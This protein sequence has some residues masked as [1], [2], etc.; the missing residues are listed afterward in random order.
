MQKGT[1][2]RL[3][4]KGYGFIKTEDSDKDLFFHANEFQGE[5]ETLAEGDSVE[6]E[7]TEGQKG[8]QAVNVNKV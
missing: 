6:F 7:V 8:P 3:M 2:A 4:D 5:F 1:I